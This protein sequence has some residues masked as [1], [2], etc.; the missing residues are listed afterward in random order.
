MQAK[1]SGEG[2]RKREARNKGANG[3]ERWELSV[4]VR[5]RIERR[6]GK[7]IA[8]WVGNCQVG[9]RREEERG[10]DELKSTD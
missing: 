4:Y 7:K 6:L 5:Q 1:A 2:E 3:R 8:W 10:R 9:S